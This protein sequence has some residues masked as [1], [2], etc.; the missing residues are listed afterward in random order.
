MQHKIK[1]LSA[2]LSECM[3]ADRYRLSR[4]LSNL[5]QRLK[6]RRPV[7]RAFSEIESQISR[8]ISLR[9]SRAD[10]LPTITYPESLP[11]SGKRVAIAAAIEENQVVVIAGETGS[12]K[13]TQIPKI[14]L[15][16]GRGISG[17]IG[18]T[19]PR[20]L[21]ARSVAARIAEELQSPLGE[22]V[23]Y[24]VRFNDQSSP[25]SYI[26]LMTDG[27]LLA[28]MQQ[29]R[30]LNQY[31]TIIIDE[32]HERSLNIDFLLGIL[33]KLLPKRRD[34]KV[35]IT[36]ATINTQR[37]ADFFESVRGKKVPVIEVSGRTYP[38]ETRYHSPVDNAGSGK[39]KE[40]LE[41]PEMILNAVHE[42]G[43]DDPLGDILVFLS[44]EREIR[45]A[46]ALL[47]KSN[48]RDTEIMP[49]YSR[50]SNQEQDRVFRSHTGRRIVLATNVAETSLTV[51]GIQFV[52]D[53]GTARISRYS[54]RTKV[55]R[56]PI[57]A[58]SQASADQRKGRCGRV[59]DGICIRLYS[60][61]DFA[62]RDQFPT[63]EIQR[64]NLASVILQMSLLRLGE[65]D[66][67]PFVDPPENRL[68]ND[69]YRLL[70]EL[71][72]LKKSKTGYQ[73]SKLGEQLARLPTDP[74]LARMIIAANE[75]GALHEVL[76]IV[77][78]LS[79]QDPRE[80]PLERQQQSDQFHKSY[81]D[82]DSDFITL[83]NLWNLTAEQRHAL[84]QNQFRKW[85]KRSF[86]SYMRLR[87]WSEIYRQL[88]TVTKELQLKG[89]QQAADYGAIHKSLMT[90][91][92]SYI[93]LKN[94]I[95][96]ADKSKPNLKNKTGQ[97]RNLPRYLGQHN[98]KLDIF[99]GS[100]L[101]KKQ[102]QWILAAE[103]VETSRL[104]ARTVAKIEQQWIEPLAKHLLKS[105]YFEPHWAKK[106][107]Q[108]S[109][110]QQVTLNG[111]IIVARRAVNFGPIDSILAREL[112][113]RHAL[114]DGDYQTQAP[115][116]HENRKLLQEVEQ[117]EAK[118]RRRD[119]LVDDEEIYQFYDERI[120]EGIYSGATFDKWRKQ[121]EQNEPKLL[122]LSRG[123]IQR[124]EPDLDERDY[125]N[126]TNIGGIHLPLNYHFDPSHHADGISVEIPV[127]VLGGLQQTSFE[128]LV[129]SMLHEKIIG[130]IKSLPKAVRKNFVPA[131]NFADALMERIDTQS[132]GDL[133][134]V[135]SEHLRIMTGVS[136]ERDLW[137]PEQLPD[138]LRF[139]F[140]VVNEQGDS[141]A[142]GK[143]LNLLQQQFSG[144]VRQSIKQHQ[145]NQANEL[146]R[147]NIT[148]WDL[149]VLPSELALKENNVTFT[150]YP[151]LVDKDDSVSIQLFERVES[152]EYQH[153]RGVI[154]LL[155][156]NM[157]KRFKTLFKD[158][159]LIE[160]ICLQYAPMGRC[161]EIK[162]EIVD[163]TVEH[164]INQTI[165][166]SEPLPRN[167]PAFD[168]LAIAIRPKLYGAGEAIIKAVSGAL[169]LHR[170]LNKRFKKP[171]PPELLSNVADIRAQLDQLVYPHFVA[172]MAPQWL[173]RV[174]LYMTALQERLHK[175]MQNP[176][177][178]RELMIAINRLED[179]LQN[180][181]DEQRQH[182]ATVEFWGLLHELRL[183]LF[184]QQLKTVE[185]VSV[186]RLEKLWTEITKVIN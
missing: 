32:A 95:D 128:W 184:A 134:A 41:Q 131:T 55:Q 48:L 59:S 89:S 186:K 137:R 123:D 118:S 103:M 65:I 23:G 151:A 132:G 71:Q 107:A 49:L 76:I 152:A 168:E 96:G 114:V 147:D 27:I 98:N 108:V 35:I 153:R 11:V 156:L 58:V 22:A 171:F 124:E 159:P 116:F 40:S 72:A 1:Q 142:Q 179:N 88:K 155:Y 14:C 182:R 66:Q 63:P 176:L 87:E 109:A 10:S 64:T 3:G 21:A 133:L 81:A 60:E 29:D 117:I 100:G 73:L 68:I 9:Q 53:T 46:T 34:L 130:L 177:K 26:K 82:K 161:D 18:H 173:V 43:R 79:V 154:R 78:A 86:L 104:F 141:I 2:K 28:E 125:P 19:Q 39:R 113:I 80:R 122:Y 77:A 50:L 119:I 24:K 126:Y 138:H 94:D 83:L 92:L 31:D 102:P 178:D 145:T 150:T 67:F 181:N 146:A 174:D 70:N 157:H 149:G 111:L 167:E 175:A 4:R 36:S 144:Q 84:S 8:S 56:L 163:K 164:A 52:I 69:G 47:Q 165:G 93:S 62:G 20:R 13:T 129:P 33:K 139:N 12:G 15:E 105:N 127:A 25:K 121:V 51:P 185:T 99:P 30:W 170:E 162:Q 166:S 115:F 57:E 112:F 6:E 135:L 97:R 90:G 5:Q 85:C 75:Q 44:G 180:L 37:F 7:D 91:L 74:K 140:S 148:R 136:V 17:L 38:V 61:E 42:L 45:E 106:P 143:E 16:L 120:P 183:S 172:H 54:H 110:Y 158:L 169:E 101:S 160:K